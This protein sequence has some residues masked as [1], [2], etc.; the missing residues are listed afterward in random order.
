M[1]RRLWAEST[2][3]VWHC[4]RGLQGTHNWWFCSYA[5]GRLYI[6]CLQRNMPQ[7]RIRWLLWWYDFEPNMPLL[8]NLVTND[9][10]VQT[11]SPSLPGSVT[12]QK[13]LSRRCAQRVTSNVFP[14]CR[15]LHIV[16]ITKPIRS[17]LSTSI[18]SVVSKGQLRY[19]LRYC[20]TRKTLRLTAALMSG[21]R[22]VMQKKHVT[23]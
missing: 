21:T 5:L 16:C 2:R 7:E 11:W 20:Q 3:L 8:N 19:Q 1:R 15:H 9:L 18:S 10:L 12:T 17:N 23:R 13:C 4:S 6:G 22:L 14:Q